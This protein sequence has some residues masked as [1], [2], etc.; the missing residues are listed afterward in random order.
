MNKSFYVD[1]TKSVQE[2]GDDFITIGGIASSNIL[3]LDGEVIT[4]E[5]MKNARE[6][7][8]KW[9]NIRQMHQSIAAGICTKFDILE[10]GDT[11]IEAKIFDKDTIT[12]IKNGVLKGFSIGGKVLKRLGNKILEIIL[13]EI[14]VVDRPCNP[15][16][17]MQFYKADMAK[18]TKEEN[19]MSENQ[20]QEQATQVIENAEIPTNAT[21]EII[22]GL[23]NVARLSY[24]V[25]ELTWLQQ[26][27]DWEKEWEGD[28]SEIPNQLKA[29]INGLFG[30]LNASVA[31]ETAEAS[32]YM[33]EDKKAS[34]DGNLA[35]AGA[36]NS[37]TDIEKIQQIHDL[38]LALGAVSPKSADVI[39]L[40]ASSEDLAKS[41][42]TKLTE[43]DELIK[44]LTAEK[45]SL[46]AEKEALNIEKES[47]SKRVKELEA[48]PVQKPTSSIV[49]TM[50]KDEENGSI[51][52]SIKPVI[53]SYGKV[54]EVATLM[55]AA[56]F[57]KK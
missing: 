47:L 35:K 50:S 30:V 27:M 28:N 24:L 18:F 7:Y 17:V 11:Y 57:L 31:E 5:A 6:D 33:D 3:D 56:I 32:A 2:D 46:N 44:S 26:D 54:D 43:S 48:I 37:K 19:N 12:K 21:P 4:T 45:E 13:I 15:A 53:D 42:K 22:K 36:R 38:A 41:Y 40:S 23:D 39:E 55:K 14:S 29:L 25:Q 10:N 8:L 51:E 34:A 20:A 52:K 1:F 49:A 16:A 9:A